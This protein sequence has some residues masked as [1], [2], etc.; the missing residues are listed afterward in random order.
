MFYNIL[1]P[2]SIYGFSVSAGTDL[3]DFKENTPDYGQSGG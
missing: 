2:I 1:I 3:L